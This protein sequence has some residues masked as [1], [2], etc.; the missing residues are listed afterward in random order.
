MWRVVRAERTERRIW[1]TLVFC[2]EWVCACVLDDSIHSMRFCELCEIHLERKVIVPKTF[3]T[4]HNKHISIQVNVTYFIR[5]SI[6]THTRANECS[7]HTSHSKPNRKPAEQRYRSHTNDE[8][9]TN[10]NRMNH[11]HTASG[12]SIH[13]IRTTIR[14]FG[15]V[16]CCFTFGAGA[17]L[18][19]LCSLRNSPV[20]CFVVISENRIPSQVYL[21]ECMWVPNAVNKFCVV[22]RF[23]SFFSFL[24]INFFPFIRSFFF[25]ISFSAAPPPPPATSRYYM[26]FKGKC[27]F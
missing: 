11:R 4:I 25:A 10:W 14:I 18:C 2:A 8:T 12:R 13:I 17:T 22:G 20:I 27:I 1:R 15:F 23:A 6:H 5:K 19:W 7:E 9:K 16:L 26:L 3:C 21:C 24:G